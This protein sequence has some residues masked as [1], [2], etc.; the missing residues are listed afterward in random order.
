LIQEKVRVFENSSMR[1]FG[2]KREEERRGRIGCIKGAICVV[3]F[4]KY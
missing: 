4:T 3:L 1:R 2:P